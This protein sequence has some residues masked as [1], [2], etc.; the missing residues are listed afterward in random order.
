MQPLDSSRTSAASTAASAAVDDEL[1]A[2]LGRA[3]A[4]FAELRVAAWRWSV[5][6]LRKTQMSAVELFFVACFYIGLLVA[7][8]TLT[9]VGCVQMVT[10]ARVWLG[11]ALGQSG[12][13]EFAAGGIAVLAAFGVGFLTR[14]ILRQRV[15]RSA[16]QQLQRQARRS[17]VSTASGSPA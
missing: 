15:V 8:T 2:L 6:A 9:I 12:A 5:V 11:A 3:Q 7:L 14:A 4:E 13:G 17:A 16:R 10:G 1:Q